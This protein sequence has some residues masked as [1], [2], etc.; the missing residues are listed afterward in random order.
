[1]TMVNDRTNNDFAYFYGNDISAKDD[2]REDQHTIL[3]SS[4]QSRSSKH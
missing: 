4:D 3:T 1:M 2:D